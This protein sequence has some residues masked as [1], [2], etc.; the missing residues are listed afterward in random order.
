MTAGKTRELIDGTKR[1]GGRM[2]G[3]SAWSLGNGDDL[4]SE[5]YTSDAAILSYL[6]GTHG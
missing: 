2:S 4:T 1:S 5:L 3:F 6:A